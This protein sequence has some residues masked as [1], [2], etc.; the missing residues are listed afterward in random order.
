MSEESFSVPMLLPVSVVCHSYDYRE[1]N[2]LEQL[3]STRNYGEWVHVE[4]TFKEFTQILNTHHWSIKLQYESSHLKLHVLD[5][6]VF[7]K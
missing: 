3:F 5:T 1:Q 7:L 4:D 6:T 2:A